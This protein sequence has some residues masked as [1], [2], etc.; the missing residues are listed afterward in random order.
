[1]IYIFGPWADYA[2][3]VW[4]THADG[5]GRTSL[6]KWDVSPTEIAEWSRTAKSQ[7]AA[8]LLVL[9]DDLVEGQRFVASE[10]RMPTFGA[11]VPVCFVSAGQLQQLL[12]GTTPPNQKL[13]V[14][15]TPSVR[16][17]ETRAR[18]LRRGIVEITP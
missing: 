11:V 8:T 3:D 14:V 16:N 2:E 18:I 9:E 6:A 4:S 17:A 13:A 12:Q 15:L 5:A 7:G 10:Q 1:V